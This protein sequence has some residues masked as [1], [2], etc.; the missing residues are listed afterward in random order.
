MGAALFQKLAHGGLHNVGLAKARL[1]THEEGLHVTVGAA[2][3]LGG[4]HGHGIGGTNHKVVKG[5]APLLAQ[6]RI[7][8]NGGRLIKGQCLDERLRGHGP[9]GL[10]AIRG[11]GGHAGR[12]HIVDR[13]GNGHIPEQNSAKHLC[14]RQRLEGRLVA[15]DG[16]CGR[17]GRRLATMVTVGRSLFH[18]LPIHKIPAQQILA[19]Y[20]LVHDTLALHAA[21]L[22]RLTNTGHA[23]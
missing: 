13:C 9:G 5:V 3:V 17:L 14:S 15:P 4:S 12:R 20:G 7:T 19:G 18:D 16:S 21:L 11:T 2:H 1:G 6:K 22:H 8:G 23:G 10:G